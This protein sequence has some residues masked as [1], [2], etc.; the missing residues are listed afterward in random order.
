MKLIVRA[1]LVLLLPACGAVKLVPPNELPGGAKPQNLG[2]E[3]GTYAGSLPNGWVIARGSGGGSPDD[4]RYEVD[5][6]VKYSS[7]SSLRISLAAPIVNKHGGLAQCLNTPQPGQRI[8]LSGHLRSEGIE[9]WGGSLWIQASSADG[10]SVGF[11]NM[12][13]RTVTGSSDWSKHSVEIT[14]G[15]SAARLC[16]GVFLNG[17]GRLWADEL[18]L[19]N[20]K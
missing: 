13:G 15:E 5:S 1:A 4:Y 16:F 2:F 17:K 19:D 14:P 12:N 20:G 8:R 3:Q 6:E 10:K 7:K 18:V 11:Q 9:G